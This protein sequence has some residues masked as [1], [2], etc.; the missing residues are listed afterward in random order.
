MTDFPGFL[1]LISFHNYCIKLEI[2]S[3]WLLVNI[4]PFTFYYKVT[5]FKNE[6]NTDIISV[7]KKS[8]GSML[9]GHRKQADGGPT[10]DSFNTNIIQY[11]NQL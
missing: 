8:D 7:K 10:Q 1:P 2:I 5:T 6:V 3:A 11:G 4:A 9:L